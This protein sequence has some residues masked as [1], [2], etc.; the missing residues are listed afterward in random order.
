[1]CVV[2]RLGGNTLSAHSLD[3]SIKLNVTAFQL[4]D[5]GYIILTFLDPV[6]CLFVCFSFSAMKQ[7]QDTYFIK[8]GP[9]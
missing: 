6:F 1:M 8:L 2:S 4:C 7:D 3:G 9:G 5:L